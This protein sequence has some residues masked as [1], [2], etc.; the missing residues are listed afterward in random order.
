MDNRINS[1]F[2]DIERSIDEIFDFLPT[3]RDFL[4]IKKT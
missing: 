1:W 2:E 4:Y 3:E